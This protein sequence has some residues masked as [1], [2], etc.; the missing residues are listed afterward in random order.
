M[1]LGGSESKHGKRHMLQQ[2][3][4]MCSKYA[5]KHVNHSRFNSH[6]D[7]GTHMTTHFDNESSIYMSFKTYEA[8]GYGHF[9]S[10]LIIL[11]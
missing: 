11:H 9:L 5:R 3:L 8:N 1:F 10:L 7:W 4:N 2:N 6:H